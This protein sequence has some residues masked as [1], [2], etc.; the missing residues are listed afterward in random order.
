VIAGAGLAAL[1]AVLL[2]T[3]PTDA[4]GAPTHAV[5]VKAPFNATATAVVDTAT[6]RCGTTQ[7]PVSPQLNA[8]S[9]YFSFESSAH[10][11]T[12]PSARPGPA[13][14]SSAT[15]LDGFNWTMPLPALPSGLHSVELVAQVGIGFRVRVNETGACP[16]V[17]VRNF[18]G[19]FT[20]GDCTAFASWN[21][22]GN[23]T[24]VD[25]TNG[26]V[27][28]VSDG[29]QPATV[30]EIHQSIDYGCFLATHGGK[31]FS[32]NRSSV[33]PNAS[34]NGDFR[35]REVDWANGTFNASHRYE[36]S[37][38]GY[39]QMFTL[40]SGWTRASASTSTNMATNGNGITWKYL[41][42]A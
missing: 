33:T 20:H 38:V 29:W 28:W 9:G 1:V 39:V 17:T 11:R 23:D 42:I 40:V 15:V 7:T 36:Y 25:L 10:A 16:T 2:L 34:A 26:S 18:V 13:T 19:T 8:T 35:Y 6:K 41:R 37:F 24:I 14:R 5:V 22:W 30:V 4:A 12:C 31:C 3:I 32:D 21:A 27:L